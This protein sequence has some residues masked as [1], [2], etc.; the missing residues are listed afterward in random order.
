MITIVIP[1]KL[2]M[3]SLLLKGALVL[4]E[5]GDV[6]EIWLVVVSVMDADLVAV[7]VDD[8]AAAVVGL[9]IGVSG[10]ML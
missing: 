3:A 7:V 2:L 1:L 5:L 8:W 9:V 10:R 4:D 6:V